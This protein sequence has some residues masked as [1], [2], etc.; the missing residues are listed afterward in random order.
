[1]TLTLSELSPSSSTSTE[2]LA[3][4]TAMCLWAEQAILTPC[5]SVVAASS[6]PTSAAAA[7]NP[8]AVAAE[9]YFLWALAVGGLLG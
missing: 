7:A 3:T 8:L 9:V 6:K 1:M 5:T 2:L 4:V